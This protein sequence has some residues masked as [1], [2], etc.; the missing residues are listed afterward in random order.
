MADRGRNQ[1]SEGSGP[2]REDLDD[3]QDRS[4][5]DEMSA[6]SRGGY[7]GDTVSESGM[8]GTSDAGTAADDA[9]E[10]AA[11]GRGL[12]DD[13]TQSFP[14]TEGAETSA[15]KGLRGFGGSSPVQGSPPVSMDEPPEYAAEGGGEGRDQRGTTAAEAWSRQAGMGRDRD[16]LPDSAMGGT[17]DAG[18]AAD[19]AAEA[20]SM[21]RGLE[22]E[23]REPDR[24]E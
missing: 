9:V 13:A 11:L 2:R 16:D 6:R 12:P 10:A 1:R 14:E 15:D 18:T 24:R 20:A 23:Q 8:G 21:R 17:S 22:D 4:A 3:V 19:D 7:G 5:A